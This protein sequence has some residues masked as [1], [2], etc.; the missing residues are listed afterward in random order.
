MA[1]ESSTAARVPQGA[2]D[3]AR[4]RPIPLARRRYDLIFA[5]FFLVNLCFITYIVDLEQL[6]IANPAHFTYPLWPPGPLVDL[7]HWWGRTFDP[8]LLARPVWWKATIWVDA[9]LYGPFYVAAIYAFLRA[10]DWIRTPALVW[11]GMMLMG[12]TVILF[13]ERAGPYATPQ[14]GMVL[15]A[16]LPWLLLPLAVIARMARSEH[17]FTEAA[18]DA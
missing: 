10:K 7:V 2:A 6:V 16:N 1:A 3:H 8:V 9:A 12:V 5:A 14:F 4:R 11:A 15:A 17:P 18:S 13:E